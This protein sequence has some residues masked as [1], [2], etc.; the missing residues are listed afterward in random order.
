MTRSY[1]PALWRNPGGDARPREVVSPDV[2]EIHRLFARLVVEH[3]QLVSENIERT[4]RV[5]ARL[6]SGS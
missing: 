6:L 4:S 5:A 3:L 1:L 2:F